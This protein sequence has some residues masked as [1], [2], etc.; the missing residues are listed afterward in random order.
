[1][2][3][4]HGFYFAQPWWLASC[5]LA[6]P[7]VWIAVRSLKALTPV[8]RAT[9]IAL[10]VI[11]VVLLGVLLARPMLTERNEELT[12]ITVV[13]RSRSVRQD[14]RKP[15]LKF[16]SDALK[17]AP[18]RD[19]LA[20]VDVAE[21]ASISQLPSAEMSVR[22]R[23]ISLLGG[24]SNLAAG[25]Q[26]AM[27][28]APPESATRILLVSDGNE[29]EGD[30]KQA[31]R[32][33]A[34][35]GIP[36]DVLPLSYR[37]EREVVFNRLV[38]PCRARSGQT[39][40]LRFVLRS[41][42][43][44]RGKLLLSLNGRAV[45]L[46]PDSPAVG[47]PVT[48]K[49]GTNVKTVSVPLGLRGIHEFQA[50]F[51][52]AGPGADGIRENNR[53]GAIT[54]VAGPGYVLVVDADGAA[55][56]PIAQA[57]RDAGIE[58]R[59]RRTGEFPDRITSLVDKD[60]IVLVNAE[61]LEFSLRQQKMLCRYVTELGGGLVMVGGPK[62]FGAGGW[63]GSPLAEVL[64]L[65]P[66]PPQKKQMPKGA[67]VLIMHACEMPKGNYWGKRVATAAVGSLSRLD[68]VGVIDFNWTAGDSNWVFP[69]A[70]A[71]D[72]KAVIAAIGKMQM[73]DMPDF[74]A[75]MLAAYRK[76]KACKAG[77]K[78]MIIISDGDP[79]PPSRQLL[80]QLSKAQITCTGV[81]VFPHSQADVQS[82]Q[83]IAKAT[84]GRFYDVKKA[85]QL[86]HIFV[87]EAQVVRRALI[88]E[89][90]FTPRV[91]WSLHDILKGLGGPIPKLEGYVLT[92]RKGGLSQV[93]LAGPEGDP[94]L[95]TGQAGLGRCAAF[96]SS[97][98]SRWASPWLKWG[99]FE[100]FWEQTV[101]WASKSSQ[102]TDCEVFADVHGRDVTVT[103]EAATAA[104]GFLRL[105]D[106]TGQVI[107]PDMSTSTLALRQVGPGRY[108]AAFRA[109]QAG[110]HLVTVRYRKPGE[111]SGVRLVQ[112][113]VTVPYA[114]EFRDLSDNAALLAEVAALTGGRVLSGDA[115][116][117][118]LFSR[119]GIKFPETAKPL[120]RPIIFI[121]LAAFLLDVAV[122]RIA[123]D[124]R[125]TLRRLAGII[126]GLR[127]REAAGRTL[128][129]LMLRRRRVR[130]ELDARSGAAV[131]SRRYE[132]PQA[133]APEE[134]PQVGQIDFEKQPPTRA[135]EP[136]V[137]KPPPAEKDRTHLD[138][139]LKAKR[140]ARDRMKGDSSKQD[141]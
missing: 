7:V 9:A 110:S 100:R 116:T 39:V 120:T 22:E 63:I 134:L 65:D 66:D 89:E 126:M 50:E 125:A 118:N 140:Q 20:V 30:L 31:A 85:S 111:E 24:Q 23:N 131:A 28:I 113:A 117:V 14:L 121:W 64:P 60:A 133:G 86:P 2:M 58:V 94:I 71:G 102:P 141:E 49:P 4:V 59:H 46:D 6:V 96:T 101:R 124:I 104:G 136:T 25:V 35:N 51:I 105:A 92:G 70:P 84:G 18:R 8:R 128:D 81:A 83:R 29:T 115:K 19:R 109:G 74:H 16:L 15:A 26:M 72:R 21:A 62:S 98:D 47:V 82:L 99:G 68:L 122:R 88:V 36:V 1:M 87:K 91:T 57:L 135:P 119:K 38:A 75:P 129:R 56:S 43:R 53:A 55:G 34:A 42:A 67:L 5:A 106:I 114:P 123:W 78:H 45:D 137:K 97:A 54:F 17:K 73:G 27:A 112:S 32:I 37:H 79:S 76:L 69:L 40:S 138:R 61:R 80:N 103:V 33:A 11:V 139:L 130:K 95:A 52:P 107:A 77:Q 132:A 93:V 127:R 108:R 12:L 90:P 3:A 41:T 48:L 13:D 10:R 44:S